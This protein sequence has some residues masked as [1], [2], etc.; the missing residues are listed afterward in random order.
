MSRN[1]QLVFIEFYDC[2][3]YR[4]TLTNYAKKMLGT[5]LLQ[6]Y[7]SIKFD[8]REVEWFSM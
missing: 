7:I 6:K 3:V 1:F 5:V 8:L 2:M 4:F